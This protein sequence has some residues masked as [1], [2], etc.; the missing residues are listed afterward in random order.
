MR[1]G[2]LGWP[3]AGKTTLFNALTGQRQA[4][5]TFSSAT[6]TAVVPVPDARIDRLSAVFEPRKTTYAE[7]TFVDAAGER[8][9]DTEGPGFPESLLEAVR[10]TDALVLVVRAFDD[11]RVPRAPGSTTPAADL[12][13]IEQELILRDLDRVERRLERLQKEGHKPDTAA[14]RAALEKARDE[15][16][17]ERPLRQAEWSA[18]ELSRLRGFQLLSL[19]P[20]LVV[21]NVGEADLTAAPPPGIVPAPNRPVLQLSAQI[22]RELSE[23]PAAEQ[24]DFLDQLG[25]D[26]PVRERFVRAAF[27]LLDLI[28]FFTV[29]EDEVRAWSVRRGATAPVAA[30]RIH[31]DLQKGFIRAEVIHYDEFMRVGSMAG[32]RT[33]GLLRLEGKQYSVSDGDILHV[34]HS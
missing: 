29:G 23:L 22:E 7:I 1:L 10:D 15:L 4:T 32:A 12:E 5:G 6:H 18:E 3:G 11:P 21:L 14:E 26:Q 17:A 2:L 13:S 16:H 31:T 9:P 30:G 19:K 20:A 28:A 25:L 27:A 34:R 8:N 33:A 24:R